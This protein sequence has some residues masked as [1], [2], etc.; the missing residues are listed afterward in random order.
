MREGGETCFDDERAEEYHTC[1]SN[2][3]KEKL[4]WKFVRHG[5]VRPIPLQL[6]NRQLFMLPGVAHC[7]LVVGRFD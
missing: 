4:R 5:V 7:P 1:S 3:R 2:E 6:E